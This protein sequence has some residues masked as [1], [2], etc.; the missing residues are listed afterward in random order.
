MAGSSADQPS[1]RRAVREGEQA[2]LSPPSVVALQPCIESDG[3]WRNDALDLA[4]S[5]IG[6][7]T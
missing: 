4:V 5:S 1:D 2:T 7:D 6:R 3:S